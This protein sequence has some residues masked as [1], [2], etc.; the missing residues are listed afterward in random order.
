[1]YYWV[2]K[3]KLPCML[4]QQWYHTGF[5]KYEKFWAKCLCVVTISTLCGVYI[6]Q[7]FSIRRV[8]VWF[9]VQNNLASTGIG[10][11]VAMNHPQLHNKVVF[12]VGFWTLT[13]HRVVVQQWADN[14]SLQTWG[15][16]YYVYHNHNQAFLAPV[17]IAC[18]LYILSKWT[19]VKGGKNTY[20]AYVYCLP[21]WI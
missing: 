3:L 12:L 15:S 11:I 2:S 21:S 10:H 14:G 17:L 20:S 16:T 9:W 8:C 6:V 18:H 13:V 5:F 7:V 1:M 19:V 4:W